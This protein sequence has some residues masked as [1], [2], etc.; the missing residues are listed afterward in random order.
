MM[1]PLRVGIAGLGTVGAGVVKLL[2]RQAELITARAGRP[3]VVT[4][5]SARDRTRERGISLD[6]LIWHDDPLALAWDEQV[7]VVVELIGGSDGPAKALAEKALAAGRP[8]VTA[9]KALLAVHGA[10][11]AQAA[12]DAG[13]PLAY[14][15]AV[16][17]GIPVI[18]ALREGLAANRVSRV[19]GILNGT[20]NYILT[21]MREEGRDF[22][23]VLADAQRLGYAEADPSF[24]ID[25]VDAAHKLAILAGLAFGARINFADLHIEGIRRVSALDIAFAQELGYRIKLLGIAEQT[26]EGVSLRVHPAMVPVSKPIATVDGVFNAV[27]LE[28]DFS[29]P[30]FL[31]GRGAGEGPTASAVVADLIDIARGSQIPVWGMAQGALAEARVVPMARL[32]SAYFLRLMV[33]DQPGVMADVTSILRDHGISLE[34]MLQHGRKPG[35]AV[36]IV[37]L[38]HETREDAVNAALAR[39]ATLEAVLEAPALIRIE[40]K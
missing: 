2:A 36:P 26:G 37:L 5:V 38:T 17:G 40:P 20:C 19:A 16:A 8:L 1:N 14:E 39:I 35:E 21:T 11:L 18:K 7:D 23:D 4:A 28:G 3:I 34:S 13:L 27:L 30:V 32:S 31:Q 6:G 24:D 25:G 29:G 12:E 10:A 9:N 22:A 15:A 33:V